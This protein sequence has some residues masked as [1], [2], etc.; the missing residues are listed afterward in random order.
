MKSLQRNEAKSISS[1]QNGTKVKKT[2]QRYGT[3]VLWS[4]YRRNLTQNGVRT[5]AKKS[6]TEENR[7]QNRAKTKAKQKKSKAGN[8]LKANI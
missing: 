6:Q 7:T 3:K 4:P 1:L 5:K 8:G 2:L